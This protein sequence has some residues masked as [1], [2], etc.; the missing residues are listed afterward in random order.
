MSDSERKEASSSS[1][2]PNSRPDPAQASTS[3]S[4]AAAEKRKRK[5]LKRALKGTVGVGLTAASAALL[6]RSHEIGEWLHSVAPHVLPHTGAGVDIAEAGADIVLR[7]IAEAKSCIQEGANVCLDAEGKVTALC[8]SKFLSAP[9]A[10]TPSEPH[11]ISAFATWLSC[12]LAVYILLY[13]ESP[14]PF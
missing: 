3:T 1:S 13:L 14:Y 8:K 4:P 11:A 7:A 10:G 12:K 5:T 2:S 9:L 6:A